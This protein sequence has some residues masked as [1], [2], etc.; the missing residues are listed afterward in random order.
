MNNC[1]FLQVH[2]VGPYGCEFVRYILVGC[3]NV[4]SLTLGVEWPEPAFCNVQVMY[5]K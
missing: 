4:K 5:L 1:L 3:A 2:L